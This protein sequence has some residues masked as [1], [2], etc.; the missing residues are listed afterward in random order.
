MHIRPAAGNDQQALIE[1]IDSIYRQYGDRICLD[2]ADRDLLDLETAYTAC[3]GG[4]V[5]LDDHG[6]VRGSHAVLPISLSN[7]LCTF[8]R[9]YLDPP[10]WGSDWGKQLMDWAVDWARQQGFQRVEF[11]SDTRFT[12]AHR[13]FHRYG[14]RSD[15]RVRHLQDGWQP[16]SEFYFSFDLQVDAGPG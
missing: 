2:G 7:G 6:Q 13:F 10:L 9:L 5:V 11:W 8:R 16:Y 12:R 4:F 3:G 14:F 15:G 1:L